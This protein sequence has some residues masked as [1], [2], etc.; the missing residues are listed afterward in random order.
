[1]GAQ[2]LWAYDHVAPSRIVHGC[3]A[4]PSPPGAI[5]PQRQ[6]GTRDGS[7]TP[8]GRRGD[9]ARVSHSVGPVVVDVPVFDAG[10]STAN[11]SAIGSCEP[12][13]HC[14]C[15]IGSGNAWRSSSRKWMLEC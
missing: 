8:R 11:L 2:L 12:V 7:R 15:L 6:I 3:T 9:S 5:R 1:H 10:P 13:G 4:A 14:S